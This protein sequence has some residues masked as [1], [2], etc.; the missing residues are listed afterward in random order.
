MK[1][2]EETLKRVA[3]EKAQPKVKITIE[4]GYSRVVDALHSLAELIYMTDKPTENI[5]KV[6]GC[7]PMYHADFVWPEIP[8]SE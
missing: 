8:D 1:L 3:E 7:W 2:S 4:C 5:E 6:D